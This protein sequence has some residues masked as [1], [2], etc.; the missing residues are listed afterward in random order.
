MLK[1]KLFCIYRKIDRS[2]GKLSRS[3]NLVFCTRRILTHSTSIY[4]FEMTVQQ[5]FFYSL[6][7]FLRSKVILSLKHRNVFH[8]HMMLIVALISFI[9]QAPG[10]ESI[11]SQRCV[12]CLK[13]LTKEASQMRTDY[14]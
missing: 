3:N 8:S 5:S 14:L 13:P 12:F 2:T 4:Y 6:K 1:I 10:Y 11:T 7:S 9:T